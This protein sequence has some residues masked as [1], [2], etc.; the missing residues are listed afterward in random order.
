MVY[1]V[2]F[3]LQSTARSN[4]SSAAT[5][6][7]WYFYLADKR[8]TSHVSEASEAADLCS[9]HRFAEGH[10]SPN[11]QGNRKIIGYQFKANTELFQRQDHRRSPVPGNV[12]EVSGAE[13][14]S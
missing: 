7:P 5:P 9:R 1:D 4:H 3:D 6:V 2:V 12:G 10:L 11:C 8:E 14:A 13:V